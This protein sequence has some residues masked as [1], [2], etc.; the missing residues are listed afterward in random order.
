MNVVS[1]T[2]LTVTGALLTIAP[3]SAVTAATESQA[4]PATPAASAAQT[5][6]ARRDTQFFGPP[7]RTI[8]RNRPRGCAANRLCVY[9]D[10]N[11]RGQRRQLVILNDSDW[12]NN[13]YPNSRRS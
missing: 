4:A 5:A 2:L 9:R 6:Q 3:A 11:F 7:R 8:T 12:R 13:R 1:R 10:R